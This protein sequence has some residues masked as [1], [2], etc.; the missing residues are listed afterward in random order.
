MIAAT[1][2][3]H[4]LTVLGGSICIFHSLL[5]GVFF[6]FCLKKNLTMYLAY[7]GAWTW[8]ALRQPPVKNW[9]C[10]WLRCFIYTLIFHQEPF[11]VMSKI[12]VLQMNHCTSIS[13]WRIQSVSNW[14]FHFML[15]QRLLCPTF[16]G[17]TS[18]DTCL[19]ITC[20]VVPLDLWLD[21][22]VCFLFTRDHFLRQSSNLRGV[23]YTVL[24]AATNWYLLR[25]DMFSDVCKVFHQTRCHF[26]LWL[27]FHP[28]K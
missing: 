13:W 16:P 27:V 17:L 11:E 28:G 18:L 12:S 3:D 20:V 23:V 19:F 2:P 14:A 21:A 22:C 26:L 8:I 5:D 25:K 24:R 10:T 4:H 1:N 7:P 15:R 9:D 6:V